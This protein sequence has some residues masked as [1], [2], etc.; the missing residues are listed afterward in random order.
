MSFYRHHCMALKYSFITLLIIG[1]LCFIYSMVY[2]TLVNMVN[3]FGSIWPVSAVA[4]GI[5]TD[6]CWPPP[7]ANWGFR[8]SLNLNW[9]SP[10]ASS[11]PPNDAETGQMLPK[12]FTS[13]INGCFLFCRCHYCKSSTHVS[14]LK[15]PYACKL[16]F[17]ELQSMNIVPRL[18]LRKYNEWQQLQYTI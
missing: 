7:K 18:T 14:S 6:C 2:D 17:Q 4:G 9:V 1:S 12:A 11:R 13:D 10:A 3:A 16:L 8:N 15:I 5:A